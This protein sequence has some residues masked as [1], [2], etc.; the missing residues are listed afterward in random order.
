LNGPCEKLSSL[1]WKIFGI[2]LSFPDS[3]RVH[4]AIIKLLKF[5]KYCNH[6]VLFPCQEVTAVRSISVY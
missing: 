4:T 1:E 6:P 5:T 2:P 3:R